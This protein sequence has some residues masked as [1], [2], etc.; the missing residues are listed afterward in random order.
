MKPRILRL[1]LSR[2]LDT[3]SCPEPH[4]SEL[5]TLWRRGQFQFLGIQCKAILSSKGRKLTVYSEG[6]WGVR[7]DHPHE[8]EHVESMEGEQMREIL[9]QNGCGER[10]IEHAFNRIENVREEMLETKI[11]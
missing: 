1:W 10:A 2:R 4:Q 9:K 7:S 8:I 5:L 11:P 3:Q 6:T